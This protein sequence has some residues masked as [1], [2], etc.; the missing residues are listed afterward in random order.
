MKALAAVILIALAGLGMGCGGK[1]PREAHGGS[2][3]STPRTSPTP[4]TTPI[5]A[6]RTPAGLALKS[7]VTPTSATPSPSASPSVTPP[8]TGSQPGA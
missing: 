8:K 7:E 4:D 3:Q 6:L 1:S 5:E 2:E